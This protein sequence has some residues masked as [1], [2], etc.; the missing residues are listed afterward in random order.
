M[1]AVMI[2][3]DTFIKGGNIEVREETGRLLILAA[4]ENRSAEKSAP[5]PPPLMEINR[6]NGTIR[7]RIL[8]AGTFK[9]I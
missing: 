7:P 1:L 6:T 8:F 5:L 2:L 9:Q 3:A 4:G